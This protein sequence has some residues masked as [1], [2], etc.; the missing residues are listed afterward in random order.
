[1]DGTL[2]VTL[3]ESR[4]GEACRARESVL[5]IGDSAAYR[6]I[7]KDR[8]AVLAQQ[9]EALLYKPSQPERVEEEDEAEIADYIR[10]NVQEAREVYKGRRHTRPRLFGATSDGH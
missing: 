10:R 3:V 1:M 6:K 7:W 9:P 4:E 5:E 2:Q 8:A